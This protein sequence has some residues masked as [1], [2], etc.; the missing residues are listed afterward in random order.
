MKTKLLAPVALALLFLLTAF[1]PLGFKFVEIN[2]AA[3]AADTNF[4]GYIWSEPTGEE[5]DLFYSIDQGTSVNTVSLEI[6]VSADGTN[7][8][9]HA[10]SPTL[11]TDNAADASGYIHDIPVHG[12]QFRIVANVTTTDTV[13]PVLRM[14]I[15]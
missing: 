3:I 9:N 2:T 15:R 11:L 8:Y 4:A 12:H 14:T 6:E 13:T 7:W 1:A 10:L 5:A